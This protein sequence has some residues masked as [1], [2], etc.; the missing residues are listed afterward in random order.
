MRTFEVFCSLFVFDGFF[1]MMA[2]GIYPRV[3]D[4][5]W[6]ILFILVSGLYWID[7]GALC[8]CFKGMHSVQVI[9]DSRI[10]ECFL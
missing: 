4:N 6:C 7:G 8:S 10:S 5:C 3:K 2:S 9:L 1:V